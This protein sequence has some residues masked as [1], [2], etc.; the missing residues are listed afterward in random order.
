MQDETPI[1][2]KV[3]AEEIRNAGSA[4]IADALKNVPGVAASGFAQGIAPGDP[5]HGFQ[6]RAP[7]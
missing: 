7:A 2:A 4:S 1:P 5:R 3:D 6:P